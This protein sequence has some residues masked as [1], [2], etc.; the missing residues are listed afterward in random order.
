[1]ALNGAQGKT[2]EELQGFL[3][4]G[5]RAVDEVN[6]QHRSLNRLLT[7]QSGHPTVTV[8]NRYF[9]DDK[10]IVVKKTF[11]QALEQ[12][13]QSGADVLNFSAEQAAL[14]YI[15][16][17]VKANTKEKIDKI[18]NGITPLDVAFLINAL[19]FKADWATPFALELTR[20]EA[21]TRPDGSKVQVDFV[22]ADR[23]FTFAS[24]QQ[25][26]LVDIPFRD[27]TF[28]LS[29]LQPGPANSDPK[30][31]LNLTPAVWRALYDSAQ[32]SRAMVFFPKLQLAYEADLINSLKALGVKT[33]FSERDAD[34]TRMG[35]HPAGKNIFINQVRHKV[36]LNVDEKG[37]EGAAVTSIG[38]GI[39]SVP[40]TFWFDKPF[41]LV[42]RHI[43]TNTILFL[44]Y[45]ADP[46]A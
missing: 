36:V 31:H 4:T 43:P 21:F 26:H 37:A 12:Y 9:Y 10:R 23:D 40:P 25:F 28:S 11:L 3:G 27:S 15:N 34:F 38:F 2:A 18:L 20:Q 29:L 35:T 22:N 45:V 24:T 39:N 32:Y 33:A 6:T 46:S 17:W 30:W 7:Q 13:Y 16:G 5:A 14:Q 41:I 44:G 42:L 19:H 8:A 1:M